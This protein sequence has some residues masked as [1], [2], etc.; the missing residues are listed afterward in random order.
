MSFG[1]EIGMFG[2][3][4]VIALEVARVIIHIKFLIFFT[5]IRFCCEY[6]FLFITVLVGT[7]IN[8]SLLTFTGI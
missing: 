6:L 5:V 7:Y 1:N 8:F 4:S 2:T 3:K